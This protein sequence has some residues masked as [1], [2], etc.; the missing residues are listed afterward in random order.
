MTRQLGKYKIWEH[1]A[2]SGNLC[3]KIFHVYKNESVLNKRLCLFNT[4]KNISEC[5]PVDNTAEFYAAIYIKYIY[6]HKYK[7]VLIYIEPH[8]KCVKCIVI[9]HSL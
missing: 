7:I 6:L 8:E 9:T 4:K 2:I 1:D 3:N 5:M